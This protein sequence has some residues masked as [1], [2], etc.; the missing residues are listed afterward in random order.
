[1]PEY[2]ITLIVEEPDLGLAV[3]RFIFSEDTG[4]VHQSI[5]SITVE[6]A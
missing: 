2:K 1:M 5:K 6:E 4:E 3:S